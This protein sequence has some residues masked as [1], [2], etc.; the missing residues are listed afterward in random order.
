MTENFE[1][2]KNEYITFA[3]KIKLSDMQKNI[4][5]SELSIKKIK[6]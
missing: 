2:N 1:F 6:G 5:I 4:L 3:D